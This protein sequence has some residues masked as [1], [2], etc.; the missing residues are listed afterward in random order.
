[1]G[2]AIDTLRIDNAI[3]IIAASTIHWNLYHLTPILEQRQNAAQ[4]YLEL[5]TNAPGQIRDSYVELIQRYDAEIQ[6]H[7]SMLP[8]L[9]LD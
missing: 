7:L 5:P 1:M 3:A 6:K 4:G 2:Q 9:K 8:I